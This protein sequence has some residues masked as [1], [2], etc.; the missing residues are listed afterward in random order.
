LEPAMTALT[1][2]EAESFLYR[3]ARLLDERKF[4]QWLELFTSDAIYWMPTVDGADPEEQT[5]IIYDDRASLND[6]VTRLRDP[7]GHAQKPLS[8]TRHYLTN[9]EVEDAGADAARIYSNVMIAELRTG[10]ERLCTGWCVHLMRRHGDDWR[11][12]EKKVCLLR[13]DQPVYNLTF[14]I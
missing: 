12:A 10:N 4:E 6:R 13:S 7:Y 5:P 2:A 8:R 11:I 3:E 14:L 9:V 1:R